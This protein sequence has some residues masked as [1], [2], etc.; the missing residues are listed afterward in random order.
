MIKDRE[1][2]VLTKIMQRFS[3]L[4][5]DC[6]NSLITDEK[7]YEE[8]IK[9]IH[10]LGEITDV[11]GYSGKSDII[12]DMIWNELEKGK[13]TEYATKSRATS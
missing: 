8:L 5:R 3:K 13:F 9:L 2:R 1:S 12:K 11:H 10:I 6:R 4:K 7:L